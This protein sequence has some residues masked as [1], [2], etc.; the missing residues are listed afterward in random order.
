MQALQIFA[1]PRARVHLRDRGLVPA[2]VRVIPAAAGG[3]KGLVLNTLD[4]FL[5]GHWLSD[6]A[7]TVHLMG[8]SIGAWRIAVACRADAD[9]GFAELAED[10]ITQDYPREPGKAPKKKDVTR[11][12]G[13]ILEQR[14]GFRAAELL[15]HPRFRPHVIASRGRHLLGR[16][17]RV[18]T[19]IGY[20]GAFAA[21]LVSRR[22]MG[23]WLERV[24]FSDP[25][26]ALPFSLHDYRTRQVAL[27]PVNLA[28]A[29]LASC[30]IPFWLDAVHDIEGAPRGAYWDG[31]LTDY[32]LHLDY[33]QM[34]DGLVLYPHFQAT[35]V[36]GWLDKGLKHR[37]SA[38]ARLSNLVLLAP[39]PAWVTAVMPNAKLPD[40]SDFKA[41]GE[42]I[43]DRQRDWRRAVM[44][45]Q[46][47]ADEFADAVARPSID[48]QPLS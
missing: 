19:P 30:S 13:Q 47:L 31:G 11:V 7:Q 33:A 39:N 5:F 32:H 8:A 25:R 41:Y 12:F 27:T 45:S 22:A 26:D 2:D 34:R 23:G 1:G 40:R 28:S 48:A 18:R 38:T 24:M 42:R 16:E 29:V 14:L 43:A 17:G 37:H 36:P 3:P 6:A 44:E 46:R 35:V 15:A 9:A 21:N 10:Y 20:L 4:R